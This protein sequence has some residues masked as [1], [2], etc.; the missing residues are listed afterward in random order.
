MKKI[1]VLFGIWLILI[2]GAVVLQSCEEEEEPAQTLSAFVIGDW[3]SQVVD[4]G[5]VETDLYFL[6][7]IEKDFYTLSLTDGEE[8]IPLP[9]AGYTIDNEANTITIDQ[10]TFPGDEPSDEKIPFKVTWNEG[11]DTMTWLPV[12]PLEDDGPPTLIWTRQTGI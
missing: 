12:D 10:P 11:G 8:V 5:D 9:K 7:Y 4:L 3:Y 2:M 6:A 1:K